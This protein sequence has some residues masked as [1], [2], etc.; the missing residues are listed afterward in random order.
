MFLLKL[1]CQRNIHMWTSK[2]THIH[3]PFYTNVHTSVPLTIQGGL[4]GTVS[5][6]HGMDRT[7]SIRAHSWEEITVQDNADR[8]LQERLIL[9]H[10]ILSEVENSTALV[11]P[12]EGLGTWWSPLS[13]SMTT[14]LFKNITHGNHHHRHKMAASSWV[15]RRPIVQDAD[16]IQSFNCFYFSIWGHKGYDAFLSINSIW[17]NFNL[18]AISRELS[19]FW[20]EKKW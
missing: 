3:T 18:R 1:F 8:L 20:G 5:P 12:L 9:K 4:R 17:E 7:A 6:G 2:P 10:H 14:E 19:P 15:A 11:L 13:K 16:R